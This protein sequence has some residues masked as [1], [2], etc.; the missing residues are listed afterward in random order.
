MKT[1]STTVAIL[2]TL[3]LASLALEAAAGCANY[4][5]PVRMCF[6]CKLRPHDSS[7]NFNRPFGKDL[8]DWNTTACMGK[9]QQYA[10]LNPCDTPRV[11]A[12]ADP[13]TEFNQ[14]R[15]AVFLYSVCEQCCDCVPIGAK[16]W[17]YEARKAAGTLISLKRGNCAAHYHY[18]MCS[19]W[20]DVTKVIPPWGTV[21]ESAPAVCPEF[22]TW[23]FSPDAERWLRNPDAD[24]LTDN[25]LRAMAE[26]TDNAACRQKG[27]WK[28]CVRL[29]RAQGR[30]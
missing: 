4:K 25:M 17:Q 22:R 2:A 13:S 27:V 9:M 10:A 14:R 15:I 1:A 20:N 8:Y 29:E 5:L 7:G 3:C 16:P 11:A 12:I 23:I 28:K 19:I 30:I 24:G 6:Q 26:L 18:D 21:D